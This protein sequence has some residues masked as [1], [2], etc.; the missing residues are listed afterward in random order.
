MTAEI[1]S[2]KRTKPQ[3]W[4]NMSRDEQTMI[5]LYRRMTPEMQAT[6]HEFLRALIDIQ[7]RPPGEKS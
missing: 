2:L 1:V 3:V 6:F 5:R 7:V 4:S